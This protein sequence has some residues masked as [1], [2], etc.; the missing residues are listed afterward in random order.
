MYGRL[1]DDLI[2]QEN[3]SVCEKYLGHFT[4]F[5]MIL[6]NSIKSHPWNKFDMLQKAFDVPRKH[7]T[8][9]ENI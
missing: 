2:K 9:R 8:C 5:G 4:H 3:F 7:L 1:F 6:D